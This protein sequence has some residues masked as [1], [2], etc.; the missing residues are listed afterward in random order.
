M[1]LQRRCW[2]HDKNPTLLHHASDALMYEGS[3][4]LLDE[5]KKVLPT[6]RRIGE[7]Y[8]RKAE[9]LQIVRHGVVV[10]GDYQIP[11]KIYFLEAALVGPYVKYLSNIN[12]NMAENRVGVDA[13]IAHLMNAF[14]HWSYVNSG[15]NILICDLQGVGPINSD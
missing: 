11:S 8:L 10:I 9:L 12:F 2:Y 14:M 4:L 6:C 7:G 1:G 13:Q 3:A 5:F 15:G